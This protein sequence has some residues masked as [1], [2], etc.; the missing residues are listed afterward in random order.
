MSLEKNP[1][2]NFIENDKYAQ[3][4]NHKNRVGKLR[5][6]I[7]I[8]SL[9]LLTLLI[10]TQVGN[11]AVLNLTDL[12]F[13]LV[14]IIIFVCLAVFS[15]AKPFTALVIICCILITDSLLQIFFIS[16][17]R[18]FTVVMEI[19]MMI[20]VCIYLESARLVQTYESSHKENN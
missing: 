19:A 10:L 14:S 9:I 6:S 17:T 13:P 5:W 18:Y 3:I 7:Y 8:Y 2:A 16:N 20:Y 12:L 11:I 4:R 15:K 1:I